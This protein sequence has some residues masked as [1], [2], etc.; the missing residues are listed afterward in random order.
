MKRGDKDG[1]GRYGH[2]DTTSGGKVI[3]HECG[4]SYTALGSHVSRMHDMTV[5]EYRRAHGLAR[6]MSLASADYHARMSKISRERIGSEEWKRFEAARD[7]IAASHSREKD[8]F[9]K[10]AS[11]EE[12]IRAASLKNLKSAGKPRTRKCDVCGAYPPK[13]LKACDDVCRAILR[14]R[15]SGNGRG[16]RERNYDWMVRHYSGESYS[17]IGRSA[18]V[19]NRAV[20]VA[21]E[22]LIAHI[23][24]CDKAESMGKQIERADWEFLP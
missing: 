8:S 15:T 14:Y 4:K 18:G 19:S 6:S 13:G 17:A 24:M 23:H 10:R 1:H 2:L 20:G 3:C 22:N 16:K 21:V 11:S 12:T 9:I 5:D 7:P